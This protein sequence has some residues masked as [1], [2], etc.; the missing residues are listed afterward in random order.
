VDTLSSKIDY[1]QIEEVGESEGL[2]D[3]QNEAQTRFLLT[4]N[5]VIDDYLLSLQ[6]LV[7]NEKEKRYM[8]IGDS[9]LNEKGIHFVKA[10]LS[11]RLSR[12]FMLS[13][14]DDEEIRAITVQYSKDLNKH[15]FVNREKYGLKRE[16][17][18]V[19]VNDMVDIVN[20]SLRRGYMESEKKFLGKTFQ[21]KETT[22]MR[23]PP[24]PTGGRGSGGVTGFLKKLTG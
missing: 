12:S 4:N 5:D 18:P 3:L 19:I 1:Q 7:W 8:Q 13:R 21:M 11:T 16:D 22:F 20:A 15:F 6:G 2:V 17:W 24:Q 9:K 23:D 10:S 14:Y